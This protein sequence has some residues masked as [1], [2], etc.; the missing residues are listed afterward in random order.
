MEHQ[1]M[2]EHQ[3]ML[4]HQARTS[5]PML[6]LKGKGPTTPQWWLLLPGNPMCRFQQLNHF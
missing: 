1:D 3:D 2:E 4:A 5:Q 6:L